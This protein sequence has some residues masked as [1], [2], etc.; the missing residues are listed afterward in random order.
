MKE[1]A[2][3]KGGEREREREAVAAK[4]LAA[5][6]TRSSRASERW[7]EGDATMTQAS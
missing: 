2:M 6:A 3:G 4:K 5:T 7:S 1:R